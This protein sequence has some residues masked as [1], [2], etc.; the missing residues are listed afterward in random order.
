MATHRSHTATVLDPRRDPGAARL[1]RGFLLW[2]AIERKSGRFG[3]VSLYDPSGNPTRLGQTPCGGA[4]ATRPEPG[5]RGRLVAFV[6]SGPPAGGYHDV[7]PKITPPAPGEAY[8][9]G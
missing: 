5:S 3:A 8:R 2:P 1:G 9:L 6:V 7:E 4:E